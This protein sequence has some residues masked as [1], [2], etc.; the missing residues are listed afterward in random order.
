MLL[1]RELGIKDYTVHS[2][3]I[4]K[5]FSHLD[6]VGKINTL[7]NSNGIEVEKIGIK[8]QKL[9]DYFINAIGGAKHV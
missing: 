7:L 6:S 5:V 1:E 3:N 2:D 9:E 8:G 4:I